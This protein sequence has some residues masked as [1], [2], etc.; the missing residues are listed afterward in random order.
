[1]TTRTLVMKQRRAVK[2]RPQQKSCQPVAQGKNT[3]NQSNDKPGELVCGRMRHRRSREIFKWGN[4]NPDI[5]HRADEKIASRRLPVSD[6]ALLG[7]E[8]GWVSAKRGMV[9]CTENG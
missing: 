8:M 5:K 3:Q 6:M 4:G 1:M 9:A 2:T 7:A